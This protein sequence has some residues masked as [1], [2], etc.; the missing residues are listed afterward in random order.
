[1][2]ARSGDRDRLRGLFGSEGL[3]GTLRRL[4]PYAAVAVLA[5]AIVV[6]QWL[7]SSGY[8][9]VYLVTAVLALLVG[10]AVVGVTVADI[11]TLARESTR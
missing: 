5:Y 2:Q 4:R 1:M 3:S 9:L 6:Q 8:D 10:A 11:L 7:R